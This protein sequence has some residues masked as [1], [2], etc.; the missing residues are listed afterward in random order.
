METAASSRGTE[1]TPHSTGVAHLVQQKPAASIR[2]RAVLY[3]RQ[4]KGRMHRDRGR[5]NGKAVHT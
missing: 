3:L 5:E 2:D 4:Y 1:V